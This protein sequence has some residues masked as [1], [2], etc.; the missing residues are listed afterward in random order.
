MLSETSRQ[1]TEFKEWISAARMALKQE[2]IADFPGFLKEADERLRNARLLGDDIRDWA[3]E[4]STGIVAMQAETIETALA[5]ADA[6]YQQVLFEL[7][8]QG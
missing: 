2:W 1:L 3:S 8:G 5:M 7:K 6:E 4:D